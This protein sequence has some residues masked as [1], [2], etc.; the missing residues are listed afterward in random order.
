MNVN[1]VEKLVRLMEEHGLVEVEIEDKNG[2][3]RLKKE[4]ENK[5]EII[6]VPHVANI[7]VV[8][9]EASPAKPA[10][11][12]TPE[13]VS[14]EDAICSPLVGTFYRRSNPDMDPYV[15]VGDT[16]DEDTVVCIVEAMKIMNEIKAEKSGVIKE[17]LV[18]DGHAVEYMQ[19]IF[20]IEKA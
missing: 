18:E 2:K 10:D 15:K 17:I 5:K 16:V 3:V 8:Q 1:D 12:K 9:P 20:R 14:A 13:E 19:P 7:P 6:S 11:G 4:G